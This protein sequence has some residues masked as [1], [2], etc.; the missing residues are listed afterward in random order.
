MR[1]V[2]DAS[3]AVKWLVREEHS[4]LA[5]RLAA[6]NHELLAP[7]LMAAE[8]SSALSSKARRGEL[9]PGTAAE[10]VATIPEMVIGWAD[11]T[12]ICPDAVRLALAQ[13]LPVFDCFYLA[14][15]IHTEATLITA[16]IRFVNSLARTEHREAVVA[17]DELALT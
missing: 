3:V 15:A 14:L 7:R 17:I 2:V 4:D 12:Q 13:N 16:D 8:V 5:D 6:G 9:E 11:D 10:L 1:F